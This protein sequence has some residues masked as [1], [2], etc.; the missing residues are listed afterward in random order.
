MR[1][2]IIAEGKSDLAILT[3]ILKGALGINQSDVQYLVP[4]L[5][6][7]ETDLAQMRIE[8]FSNWSIVKKTCQNGNA[9]RSFFGSI[10]DQRFLVIHIDTAERL[11]IGFEVLQPQKEKVPSYVSQ[12]RESVS[13]KLREWLNEH[14]NERT[15]FAVAVEETE[16]WVIPIFDTTAKETGFYPNPK[17]RLARLIA[18]PTAF[19][20]KERKR[21]FQMDEF[22]RHLELSS[23]LRKSKNLGMYAEKNESLKIFLADL[24]KFST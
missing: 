22:Y 5:E 17:E 19:S 13:L 4:E 1:A 2:G 3:N 20:D 11:E 18:H 9:S 21:I 12:V 23:P 6:Y 24:L 10:D 16:A 15:I 8:Q 14:F 7:D